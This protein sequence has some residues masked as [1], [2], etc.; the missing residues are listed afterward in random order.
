VSKRI[1][2]WVYNSTSTRYG[3]AGWHLDDSPVV[4]DFMPGRGWD[5]K[6]EYQLYNWP[7][8]TPFGQERPAVFDHEPLA[9]Y[10]RDAMQEVEEAWDEAHP[11]D[12]ATLNGS[13]SESQD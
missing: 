7:A 5:G 6:G 8:G 10:L 12:M 9:R 13:G 2:R 1:G 3:I 11:P 4:I